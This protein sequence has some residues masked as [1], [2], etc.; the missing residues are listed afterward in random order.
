MERFTNTF[1]A[2][3]RISSRKC[4]GQIGKILIPLENH[5]ATLIAESRLSVKS[6]HVNVKSR[7]VYVKSR[8]VYV[9]TIK[10]PR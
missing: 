8:H 9:N 1:P 5:M 3:R 4:T 10:Q 2:S 6:R 7:H